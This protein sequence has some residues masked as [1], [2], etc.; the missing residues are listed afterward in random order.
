MPRP[1]RA[2]RRTLQA[3]ASQPPVLG[4]EIILIGC[5]PSLPSL[6]PA[7]EV[8]LYPR[9]VPEMCWISVHLPDKNGITS[10]LRWTET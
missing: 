1:A 5:S 9:A 8:A 4:I 2:Y 7:V 6:P 10:D 3:L